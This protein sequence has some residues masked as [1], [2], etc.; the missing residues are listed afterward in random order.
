MSVLLNNTFSTV[1]LLLAVLSNRSVNSFCNRPLLFS[2]TVKRN[3]PQPLIAF[4]LQTEQTEQVDP[5][6]ATI[7]EEAEEENDEAD[8]LVDSLTNKMGEMEGLWYSDDFYGLH[9]REWVK[10]SATLVGESATSALAAVK[11]TG[12]LN[13]PAGCI[14]FQTKSWPSLGSKVMAEIQIRADPKDPDGFSWLPGELTLVAKTEIRLM[15]RYNYL[16]TNEG[17]FYKQNND[18]EGDEYHGDE[19]GI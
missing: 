4:R 16:M 9:G 11:V 14:T 6:I 5:T 1:A 3:N 18:E 19:S 12:D 7:D 2:S 10:V 15:V 17:T 8:E 13:V